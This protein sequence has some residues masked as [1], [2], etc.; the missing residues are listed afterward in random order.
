MIIFDVT[1]SVIFH[2]YSLINSRCFSIVSFDLSKPRNFVCSYKFTIFSAI[3][4]SK[5]FQLD[6]CL[7][8]VLYPP[9]DKNMGSAASRQAV[10]DCETF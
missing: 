5:C 9:L 8:L 10:A 3:V 4:I 6:F 1:S 2:F 7:F